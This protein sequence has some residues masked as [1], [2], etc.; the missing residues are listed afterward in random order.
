MSGL[1]ILPSP[2]ALTLDQIK[3]TNDSSLSFDNDVTTYTY[4]PLTKNFNVQNRLGL[5]NNEAK[6]TLSQF[7]FHVPAEHTLP[8]QKGSAIEIHFV[9]QD[10]L[11][12][13]ILAMAF[14]ADVECKVSEDNMFDKIVRGEKF[15][16]PEILTYLGYIGS[17]TN[18]VSVEDNIYWCVVNQVLSISAADLAALSTKSKPADPIQPREGRDIVLV[19]CTCSKKFSKICDGLKS[20]CS[21]FF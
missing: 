18:E 19:T 9:W 13:N 12:G 3:R 14:L 1:G 20:G 17:L 7:H 15:R 8:D 10:I 16:I 4:D 2:I 11:T 5:H 21:L 6:Y